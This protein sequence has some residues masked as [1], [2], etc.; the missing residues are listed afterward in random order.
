MSHKMTYLKDYQKPTFNV[1]SVH[2]DFDLF[3]DQ[4][5]VI[6]EMTLKRQAPGPLHLHGDA[7]ELISFC[8]NGQELSSADYRLLEDDIFIDQCP[9]QCVIKIAT[10][11]Y[12]QN[13]RQLTGLYRS[14]QL[15]CTH[16]EAEGFRRITYF[17]DRPDVLAVYTTRIK[18]DKKKYPVLLSNGNL[19][20]AGELENDRHWVQWHDPFKKP[21]YLFALVAGQL[22]LVQDSY[23]TASGKTIDLRIYVEPGNENKCAHAMMALKKAMKWD[24]NYYGREYDLDIYMMVAVEHFNRGGMENKG[25]NIFNAKNILVSPDSATDQDFTDVESTIAHEYF[26]NWTGN[27]ITCRDWFQLS[28]KEGLTVFRDQE[29]TR[30]S[31][32]KDVK[33]IMDVKILFAA[34]F[35]ED[36]GGMAHP[37]RPKAYQEVNNFYTATVYYKGAEVV[38]MLHSLLGDHGFHQGMDLY[39]ERH[40][41]QAV[42]IDDF[43]KAMEDAN[44]KDLSQFKRWYDIPGTPLVEVST[45]FENHCL[46]IHLKQSIPTL[47]EKLEDRRLVIPL[48]IALFEQD[49]TRIQMKQEVL[50]FNQQEQT[51]E[52]QDLKEKPVI[53]LLRDFSAPV[54]LH[55][56]L[57]IDERLLLLEHESNGFSQWQAAQSLIIESMHRCLDEVPSQWKMPPQ[58]LEKFHKIFTTEFDDLSLKADL[59]TPPWHQEVIRHLTD[60]DIGKIEAIRDHVHHEL[61]HALFNKARELYLRLQLENDQ[62][63]DREVYARRKFKNTCLWL[64]MKGKEEEAL[65][66]CMQ[67][68]EESKTMTDQ[69]ASLTLL[70]HSKSELGPKA[71]DA[72]YSQWQNNPLV[73]DKWFTIQAI[74]E[75]PSA[76]Q[77]VKNLLQHKDFSFYNP[78]N[79]FALIGSF[80]MRNPRHF[81]AIDGSGYRFLSDMLLKIDEINPQIAAILANPLTQWKKLNKPRQ[82]LI[83]QN[84]QNLSQQPLS[85]NLSEVVEKSLML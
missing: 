65:D 70:A 84:L 50:E 69:L 4:V 22:S 76:L 56:P 46:K 68:F 79:I 42:T 63:M 53:S 59:F 72:F 2:L 80:S 60:V 17:P 35:T 75:S 7:L 20:S 77:N 49:G 16:C 48:A 34:Q 85:N 12:P 45:E 31:Y 82:E 64:M 62:L 1:E 43:I 78:N 8:L 40:D 83:T 36:A 27:R 14:K 21:S 11:I 73:I 6:N 13:N 3:D 61:G 66:L 54:N 71:C 44:Q 38:R 74:S 51:F 58:V 10:R 5:I 55:Y 29:Y 57:S 23:I 15:F 39:F 41:G 18:A 19:I 33:R 9:D 67:Q 30:T 47:K 81:H 37:V 24:E 32:S 25:L 26:H 28:L 52:F